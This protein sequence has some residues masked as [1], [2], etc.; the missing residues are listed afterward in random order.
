MMDYYAPVFKKGSHEIIFCVRDW[1]AET[2]HE[3]WQ[4]GVGLGFGEM[5]MIGAKFSGSVYKLVHRGDE[6]Y[7][8]ENKKTISAKLGDWPVYILEDEDDDDEE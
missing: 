8:I 7:Y 4:I 3:A 6:L 5:M 2:E 1:L